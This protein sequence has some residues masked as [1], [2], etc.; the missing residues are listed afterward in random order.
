LNSDGGKKADH[1]SSSA[2][3]TRHRRR[4][5]TEEVYGARLP[6]EDARVID[7][8]AKANKLDRS[9]AVRQGLHQFALRQKMIRTK[10]D[11]L[12][13]SLEQV[14]AE[15][16]APVQQRT[17][18]V[19]VLLS[20]LVNLVVERGRNPPDG[21]MKDGG[22]GAS[23]PLDEG[24]VA[25][26]YAHILSEQKQLLE[27]TLMAVMLALRLHVNYLIEP[28]LSASEVRADGEAAKHLRAAI[29]GRDEWCETTRKIIAR[30]G[31]R[32]LFESNFITQEDW[33]NLL[34]GYRAEDE[35]GTSR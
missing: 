21:H 29:L 20:D 8:Y 12:R 32:L 22:G 11:P 3:V 24:T 23:L 4:N 27:Q 2:V 1:V 14:V 31:K 28:V 18:E 6:Y 9:E 17:E 15:Q 25:L 13:E 30:T 33:K 5:Y 35:Q 10:K 34:A 16:I 19:M 7:D 26:P